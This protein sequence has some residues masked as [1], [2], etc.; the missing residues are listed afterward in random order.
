MLL[1]I[2]VHYKS[3]YAKAV[4]VFFN[5]EDDEPIKIISEKIEKVEAYV[6]G[7]FYKRELPCILALLKNVD[8][9]TLE[10]IIVD[11][12]VFIDDEKNH[13]LGGYLWKALDEK[14]PIIGVAK[15]AFHSVQKLSQPIFRGE[16]KSPLYV[17]AIGFELD[18]ALQKVQN[19]K[20]D[21]RIPSILKILDQETKTE[22]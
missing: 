3:N 21:F 6:P 14:I 20:G 8:L 2:D 10:A 15:T 4:G 7:Q 5:W 12:H 16:S 19:M 22:F 1:A 17:S 18:L 13:G 11:G 9:N